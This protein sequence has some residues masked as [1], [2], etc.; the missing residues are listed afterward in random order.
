MLLANSFRKEN[1]EPREKSFYQ[2]T[3]SLVFIRLLLKKTQKNISTEFR[4]GNKH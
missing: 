3:F 1:P 4:Y 2:K